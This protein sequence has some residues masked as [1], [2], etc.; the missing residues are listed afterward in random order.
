[1]ARE[2]FAVGAGGCRDRF[3][4]GLLDRV[5]LIKPAFDGMGGPF[6][7]SQIGARFRFGGALS[8]Q[9]RGAAT[10]DI[11]FTTERGEARMA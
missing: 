11:R 4:L 3:D 5:D 6:E 7:H 1:M 10:G 9:T 8:S 2:T